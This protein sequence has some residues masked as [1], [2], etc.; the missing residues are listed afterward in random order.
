L[1]ELITSNP[2]LR[3]ALDAG[4][5]E[6]ITGQWRLA[7]GRDRDGD[8]HSDIELWHTIAVLSREDALARPPEAA[9]A[10]QAG[11]SAT[12][13]WMLLLAEPALPSLFGDRPH[14]AGAEALLRT[15]LI[16]ELLVSQKVLLTQALARRDLHAVG[17]HVRCL[18]G[19]RQGTAA[20]R[21]LAAGDFTDIAA[22]IGS[23]AE[24]APLG[25]RARALLEEWGAERI[26]SGQLRLGE[27]TTSKRRARAI[28]ADYG[29]AIEEVEIVA[30]LGLGLKDVLRVALEWHNGWLQSIH[31]TQDKRM[32]H[33]VVRSA[34][35]FVDILAPMCTPGQASQPEVRTI[36]EYYIELGVFNF[37]IAPDE[38]IRLLE[39][40]RVWNPDA[41]RVP[42][43]LWEAYMR[44]LEVAR[45]HLDRGSLPD[46]EASMSL[47][48]E[49]RRMLSTEL[50]NRGVAKLS[51]VYDTVV[52]FRRRRTELSPA[53][54][55]NFLPELLDAERLL[56][57]AGRLDPHETG[58]GENL[59]QI[60]E[61]MK[62]LSP[63]LGGAYR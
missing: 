54:R 13:L 45:K 16:D 60:R 46:A 57:E 47:V 42:D 29:A 6:Q 48:P 9:A 30:Q 59:E 20:T 32:G 21:S 18:D 43:L 36:A 26:T 25:E 44:C 5:R 37:D 58:I 8:G 62:I 15:Q 17:A 53:Q 51:R 34:T 35:R 27:R 19:V 41:E 24:F 12:A 31:G 11:I 52:S 14:A 61:L 63:G 3:A 10:A 4:R 2:D 28:V 38:S 40:A 22:R 7:V 56:L 50:N 49:G 33:H 23:E 39:H 1:D 55:A